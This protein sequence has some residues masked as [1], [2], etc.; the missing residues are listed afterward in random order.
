[1]CPVEI[2]TFS[3]VSR[4]SG[5]WVLVTPVEPPTDGVV[6]SVSVGLYLNVLVP[7]RVTL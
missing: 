2:V 6:L 5:P 3:G 1:M 4:I 7:Y